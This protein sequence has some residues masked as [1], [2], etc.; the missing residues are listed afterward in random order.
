MPK[1][2]RTRATRHAH[3]PT[4]ADFAAK[5]LL[6]HLSNDALYT[7]L[8]EV[9]SAEDFRR[10]EDASIAER[11]NQTDPSDDDRHMATLEVTFMLGLEI[12]RRIGGAK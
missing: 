5:V 2:K 6:S 7:E 12:G 8:L 3:T 10:L 11:L 9:L 1:K 4:P